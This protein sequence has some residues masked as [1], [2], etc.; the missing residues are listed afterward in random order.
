MRKSLPRL[1]SSENATQ[2]ATSLDSKPSNDSKTTLKQKEKPKKLQKKRPL[3]QQPFAVG[4]QKHLVDGNVPRV[5]SEMSSRFSVRIAGAQDMDH[6]EQT[7][8]NAPGRNSRPGST[9]PWADN[10]AHTFTFPDAEKASRLLGDE[11]PPTPPHCFGIIARAS[12]RRSRVIEDDEEIATR[13]ADFGSVAQSIG[14]SPYDVATASFQRRPLS[15][16][17][18]H[19]YQMSSL[20]PQFG[21]RQGWDDETAVRMAQMRSRERAAAMAVHEQNMGDRPGMPPRPRSYHENSGFMAPR[22]IPSNSSDIG[23]R[24][25]R[26][27]YGDAPAPVPAGGL[28]LPVIPPRNRALTTRSQSVPRKPSFEGPVYPPHLAR[29]TTDMPLPGTGRVAQLA[30]T[31]SNPTSAALAPPP[32]QALD[33]SQQAG[34]WRQRKLAAQTTVSTK[35][36]ETAA[37]FSRTTTTTTTTVVSSVPT[38]PLA[39]SLPWLSTTSP[40]TSSPA[41]VPTGYQHNP[42][43]RQRSP[44]P[45]LPTTNSITERRQSDVPE[46]PAFGDDGIF[47]RYGGGFY[48]ESGRRYMG[49]AGRREVSVATGGLRSFGVDLGDVPSAVVL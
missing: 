18:T 25:P 44:L 21:P 13:V 48:S 39:R 31:F 28:D 45:P 14:S 37:P 1:L 49:A 11:P 24:R 23:S 12:Q 38:Q 46:L 7:V 22:R 2:S 40:P 15:S 33:W 9:G 42:P 43:P 35:M 5:P 20:T 17:P 6:L 26:S 8:K 19:P 27:L 4:F 3:S 41:P 16:A 30:Q 32:S 34:Q 47:G 10:F 36:A 29:S